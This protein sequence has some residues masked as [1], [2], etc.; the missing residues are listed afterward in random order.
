[1]IFIDDVKLFLL[2]IHPNT[3][4]LICWIEKYLIVIVIL[5]RA[6]FQEHIAL[7]MQP[8]ISFNELSLYFLFVIASFPSKS[9]RNALVQIQTA[10]NLRWYSAHLNIETQ[11]WTWNDMGCKSLMD[12][13]G[14]PLHIP[15]INIWCLINGVMKV[16]NDTSSIK[17]PQTH[18]SHFHLN[19]WTAALTIPEVP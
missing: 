8:T 17:S 18:H 12:L 2:Y 16:S 14:V 3:N 13:S 4:I 15:M 9:F 6:L 1:M 19:T 11:T 5:M 10:T 7:F